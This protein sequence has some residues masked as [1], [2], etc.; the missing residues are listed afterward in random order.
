MNIR[1]IIHPIGQGAFYSE[2]LWNKLEVKERTVVYDCGSGNSKE[3]PK[4]FFQELDWHRTHEDEQGNKPPIDIL[5]ISHFDADHVNGVKRLNDRYDIKRIVLPEIT[6]NK[7]YLYVLGANNGQMGA[8]SSFRQFIDGFQGELI[9]IPP[10]DAENYTNEQDEGIDIERENHRPVRNDS[11]IRTGSFSINGNIFW[12]YIPMNF[13]IETQKPLKLEAKLK[14]LFPN[15]NLNNLSANEVGRRHQDIKQAFKDCKIKTN[16]SSM[17]VYSGL[18]SNVRQHRYFE[19]TF[20]HDKERCF[21]RCN[22]L[23]GEACL[24]TGDA[25]LSQKR[26]GQVKK[27]R[28]TLTDNIVTL[29]ITHH[30]SKNNFN[31][32]I[33]EKELHRKLQSIVSFASFGKRSQ[34]RHPSPDIVKDLTL[35]YSPIWGV[36]EDQRS[37]LI[38]YINF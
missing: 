3:I 11:R 35:H 13:E 25:L 8:M 34:F 23:M 38:E 29:Q 26:C 31:A 9:E 14:A 15:R 28:T 37:R 33:F 19:I 5:F 22:H 7:W 12:C 21:C 10:I 27:I 18:S 32:D 4:R 30:G 17:L 36:T 24:Y 2:R 6:K 20:G 16:E 1:R